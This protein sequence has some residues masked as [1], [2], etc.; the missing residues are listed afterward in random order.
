MKGEGYDM[1]GEGCHG[2]WYAGE[3]TIYS[4]IIPY[5]EHVGTLI[6]TTRWLSALIC[7]SV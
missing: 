3:Y 6:T 2:E 1:K 5:R 7:S 4:Q